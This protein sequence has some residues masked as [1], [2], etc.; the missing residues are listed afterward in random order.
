MNYLD[1]CK[2]LA[3]ESGTMSGQAIP[4]AVTGRTGREFKIVTWI[5]DAYVSIQNRHPNW[6]WLRGEFT[7]SLTA[8]TAR[9]TAAS[10]NVERY[11]KWITEADSLTI[12]K[13]S[14]GVSDE[15]AIPRIS[16]QLWRLR[17]GRGTQNQNR[18][19]EYAVSPTGELC[20]GPVPDAGYT[21]KGELQKSA[22]VLAAND[23]TP[24]MPED[25]HM[26]IVWEALLT[27][28]EHD[29]ANIAKAQ[30]RRQDLEI[31]LELD[32]LPEVTDDSGPLA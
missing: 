31:A 7:G 19:I 17:Y 24:E 3:K 1:L 5:K 26:L 15:G 6:K 25:F 20:F 10:L 14:L 16:W 8:G 13:T 21:V 9:Y 27:L 2:S 12:Y 32:Q 4:A 11:K 22:Q 29:E 23:D 18:P 30:R 28:D